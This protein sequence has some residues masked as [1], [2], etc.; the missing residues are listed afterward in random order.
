MSPDSSTIAKVLKINIA[1]S[2]LIYIVVKQLDIMYWEQG[3]ISFGGDV[4]TSNFM[5]HTAWD[6]VKEKRAN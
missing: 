1:R 2:Q 3:W 4:H 5:V 6:L